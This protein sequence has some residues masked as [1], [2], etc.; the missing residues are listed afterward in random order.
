MRERKTDGEMR[1]K[2]QR[3]KDNEREERTERK[4]ER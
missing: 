1:K 2:R 3:T 4:T